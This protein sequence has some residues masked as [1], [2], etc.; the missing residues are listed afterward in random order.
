MNTSNQSAN[1]AELNR[2]LHNMCRTG[3]IDE[4]DHAKKKV[5]VKLSDTLKTTW[6]EW[7][8]EIGKNFVR[9]RPLRLQTPVLILCP[10]GD[11]SQGQIVGMM[12]SN[13]ISPSSTKETDDVVKFEDGTEIKYDTSA[14]ALS[15]TVK[16]KVDIKCDKD[17]S[18]K[19]KGNAL[20]EATGNATVNATAK[21]TINGLEVILTDGASGGVVCKNHVC[22]FT[23]G[24]HPQ[25]SLTVKAGG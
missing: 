14:K 5:R 19:T 15:I 6:L 10:S 16:G 3:T 24:P 21:T 1:T 22:A 20:V 13:A 8:A 4:L 12:Y 23:G 7:P 9:W 17:I 11:I 18:I 2:L 25:G